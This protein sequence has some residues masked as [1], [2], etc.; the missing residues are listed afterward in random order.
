M[1]VL[2]GLAVAA[3][4][5]WTYLRLAHGRFWGTEERLPASPDPPDIPT[6]PIPDTPPDAPTLYG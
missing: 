2:A 3:L 1:T 4:V 6:R 5:A